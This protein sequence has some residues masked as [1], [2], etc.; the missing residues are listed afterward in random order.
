VIDSN[1]APLGWQASVIALV[2]AGIVATAIRVRAEYPAAAR[3]LS[4]ATA[5]ISLVI[6]TLGTQLLSERWHGGFAQFYD[7]TFGGRVFRWME[8]QNAASIRCCV[9]GGR[10]YP[11]FGSRRQ[12]AVFRSPYLF[13]ERE[14]LQYLH[15]NAVAYIAS[16]RRMGTASEIRFDR[17]PDWLE[18][19]PD[20]FVLLD[21]ETEHDSGYQVW[22]VDRERLGEHLNSLGFDDGR[23]ENYVLER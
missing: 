12:F 3:K 11:F 8:S 18:W 6:A 22:V 9:L 2:V 19:Y 10:Y 1:I 16:P 7:R 21:Q 13:S 5:A 17:D 23:S 15:D 14:A 20:V 4:L